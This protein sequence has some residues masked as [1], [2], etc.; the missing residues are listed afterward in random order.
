MYEL[1][2]VSQSPRR[3]DLLTDAGY[4]FRSDSVK[5]SEIIDENVNL[6]EAIS[7]LAR[8]KA[9]AYLDIHKSLKGQKI[10][11]LSADTV[12]V[13]DHQV[14]GKPESVEQACQFLR[15]M[16]GREHQVM[17]GISLISLDDGREY[18][19]T[20]V[21]HVVFRD[22]SDEEIRNYVAT[23]EPMDKAGAYG[24]QGQGRQLVTEFKGSRTNIIGLPMERLQKV[25]AEYSWSIR[26][27]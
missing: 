1:L 2:L 24:L 19:G 20:E 8:Y 6:P 13:L 14:L 15:R 12:V 11:V 7:K 5:V 21:S 22:L 25:L 9:Q 4:L 3:R 17:T 23:G 18:Q 10:L 26:M 27:N 16:S